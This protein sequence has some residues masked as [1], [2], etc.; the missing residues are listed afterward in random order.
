MPK[1]TDSPSAADIYL[2]L[3]SFDAKCRQKDS[4]GL[5]ELLQGCSSLPGLKAEHYFQMGVSAGSGD[6]V[7]LDVAGM[8]FRSGLL[9]L[10]QQPSPDYKLI[11][12]IFRKLIGIADLQH[13]DGPKVLSLY[14]E[15]VNA[16]IGLP[17]GKYPKDE[18][19]WLVATAWNRAPILC[20]FKREDEAKV[21]M[22]VALELLEHVPSMASSKAMMQDALRELESGN[23]G[24]EVM[25]E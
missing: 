5:L 8:A 18:L 7:Q 17:E 1:P 12:A 10:L 19:C 3:M 2:L 11:A 21:W 4:K 22:N 9:L 13:R 20:R 16:L 23:G 25:E 15:A 6:N 24:C 14:K